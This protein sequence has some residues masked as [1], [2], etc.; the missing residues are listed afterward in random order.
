VV[1]GGVP[2]VDEVVVAVAE[3]P[4]RTTARATMCPRERFGSF[5]NLALRSVGRRAE[6]RASYA[7][8][9][10]DRFRRSE[11]VVASLSARY[12]ELP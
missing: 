11:A 2:V 9:T 8:I 7:G 4:A 12:T 1:D 10:R 5:V 6:L 3:H